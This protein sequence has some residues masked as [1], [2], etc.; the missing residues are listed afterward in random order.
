MKGQM[1]CQGLCQVITI[2]IVERISRGRHHTVEHI[3][4]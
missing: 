3:Y 4:G 1:S 2:I